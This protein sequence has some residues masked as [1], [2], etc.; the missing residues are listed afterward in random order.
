MIA[1]HN[2]PSRVVVGKQDE[3]KGEEIRQERGSNSEGDNG[4]DERS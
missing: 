2:V 4:W 1:R 3:L